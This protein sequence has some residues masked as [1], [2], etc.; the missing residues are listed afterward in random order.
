MRDDDRRWYVI[1]T[2]SGYENKVKQ[3]L[4]HRIETMEMRD[5]IFNVIV[6]TEEEIEIKNGQRRTVQKKV[7]PG[8][9][10]V[11]MKMNDNS[12]Y[13]VRNTPGVTSFVGHGNKP[14]PLEEEEVKAILKQMEQ[15][16]PKVKVSYQVGQAVKIIDGPFTDFEGIVDAIDHERGRVR[17]LVSFFGREAPVELDFLQVTRLVE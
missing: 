13:V 9:V 5:Q 16:A 7:F 14:T 17:V 15:E 2:Y 11:Q 8:Y 4:L 3:N 10:L 12:W 6:P 1:H